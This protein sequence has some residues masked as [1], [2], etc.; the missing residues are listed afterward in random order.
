M[1]FLRE[2]LDSVTL[3]WIRNVVHM[4]LIMYICTIPTGETHVKRTCGV[5]TW[6][7]TLI[8]SVLRFV[9]CVSRLTPV[10]RVCPGSGSPLCLY[11]CL[12]IFLPVFLITNSDF[13]TVPRRYICE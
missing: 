6:L 12:L 5:V 10:S 7:C 3:E 8:D 2:G 9:R 1:F 13:V 11:L 4:Y